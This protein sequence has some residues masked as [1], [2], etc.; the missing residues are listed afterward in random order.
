MIADDL[1]F[2]LRFS[3]EVEEVGLLAVLG[4]DTA[5]G[6]PGGRCAPATGPNYGRV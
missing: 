2:N 6:T 3:R 4:E 5:V 1:N